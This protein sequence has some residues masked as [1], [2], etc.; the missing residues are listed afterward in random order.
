MSISHTTDQ[1]QDILEALRKIQDDSELNTQA[2]SNPE[3][4]LNKL[5]LSG[6]AR[7]AVSVALLFLLSCAAP[8]GGPEGAGHVFLAARHVPSD[9]VGGP[10][11]RRGEHRPGGR[12]F[13][14]QLDGLPESRLG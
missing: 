10:E 6:T 1:A 13:R 7:R 4:V 9:C 3:L 2:R 5:G 12:I 14:I 8:S 11:D